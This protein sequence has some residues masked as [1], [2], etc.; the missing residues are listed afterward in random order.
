MIFIFEGMLKVLDAWGKSINKNT[1][2]GTY[3]LKENVCI[4]SVLNCF[5]NY[6]SKKLPVIFVWMRLIF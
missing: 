5:L 4:Y 3:M 1:L 2:R 6:N